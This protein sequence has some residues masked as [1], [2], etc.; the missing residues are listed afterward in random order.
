MTVHVAPS[1][2]VVFSLAAVITGLTKK[3]MDRK[4]ERGIWADGKH[5]RL[6]DGRRYLDLV[7][8]EKWVDNGI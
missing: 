7:A 6:R 2:F 4:V 1:R 8:Y 5:F 3:A